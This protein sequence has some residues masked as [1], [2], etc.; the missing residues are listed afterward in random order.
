[1]I[2]E[3]ELE[4]TEDPRGITITGDAVR[5]SYQLGLEAELFSTIGHGA[6][7]FILFHS[8]TEIR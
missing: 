6:F 7:N 3:K 4:V 2:L 8:N 1:M 5:I